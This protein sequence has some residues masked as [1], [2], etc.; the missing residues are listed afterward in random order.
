MFNKDSGQLTEDKPQ[1]I[2]DNHCSEE[3]VLHNSSQNRNMLLLQN[4]LLLISALTL[5]AVRY[6]CHWYEVLIS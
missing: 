4:H 6:A 3:C 5:L 1:Q 2:S